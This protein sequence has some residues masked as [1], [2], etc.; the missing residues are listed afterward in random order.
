MSG[1]IRTGRVLR[2]RSRGRCVSP[3]DSS[4]PALTSTS[5]TSLDSTGGDRFRR[6]CCR[7]RAYRSAEAD[8]NTVRGSVTD[9]GPGGVSLRQV[10]YNPSK[11]R[12]R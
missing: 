12:I 6:L 11:T 10:T 1:R 9:S 7:Q 2:T 8:G 3:T 5:R 4:A